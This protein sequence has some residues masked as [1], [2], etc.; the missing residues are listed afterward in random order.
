M[1]RDIRQ[2]VK[3]LKESGVVNDHNF[4]ESSYIE[5]E[6]NFYFSKYKIDNKNLLTSSL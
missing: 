4:V 3:T 6:V 5:A 1:L 2:E